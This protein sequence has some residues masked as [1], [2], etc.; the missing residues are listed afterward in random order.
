MHCKAITLNL[1]LWW[2]MAVKTTDVS[3]LGWGLSLEA[4]FG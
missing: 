2:N 1:L 3:R 4:Q